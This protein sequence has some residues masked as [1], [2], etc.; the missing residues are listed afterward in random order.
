[1][2]YPLGEFTDRVK[3]EWETCKVSEVKNDWAQL[4][5]MLTNHEM[6][7]KEVEEIQTKIPHVDNPRKHQLISHNNELVKKFEGDTKKIYGMF[8]TLITITQKLHQYVYP[9]ENLLDLVDDWADEFDCSENAGLW[10]DLRALNADLFNHRV[11]YMQMKVARERIELYIDD[12]R[13][14]MINRNN[15][16]V[17][18]YKTGKMLIYQHFVEL[19]HRRAS[20]YLSGYNSNFMNKLARALDI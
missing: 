16:L 12:E 20:E 3:R 13:N 18:R 6:V 8:K 17:Q 7:Y 9:Y 15:E 4:M 1:M 10:S 19:D 2:T 5:S 14:Q 11:L